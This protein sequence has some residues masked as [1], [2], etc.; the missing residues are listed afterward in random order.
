M[1]TE[2]AIAPAKADNRLDAILAANRKTGRGG[3]YSVCSANRLVIEAALRLAKKRA[4]IAVI[5]ATCNQ[6][7]P[8][9]GYTGMQPADFAALVRQKAN[10]VGFDATKLVLGGDHLGPQPW[11]KLGADQAM[12]KAETM[13]ADYARAGFTKLHLDCSMRCSDDPDPLPE[14][15]IAQ[16]AARLAR[17]AEMAMATEAKALRYVIGTEVPPPGGMGAGHEIVATDP[18]HVHNTW[19]THREAFADAGL[20]DA[21]ARVVGIVV[22]PGLDFGNEQVVDFAPDDAGVLSAALD[23]LE[24]AVYEAHSTDYQQPAAYAA[25]VA[26]HFA[27]L[28]VGPQATFAMR[29]ALY[30]LELIEREL[31]PDNPSRLRETLDSTMLASPD[32]W[33]THYRE[34]DLAYLRHFSL[35]DRIRYYWSRPEVEASLARLIGNLSQ[36]GLPFPLVSQYLAQHAPMISLGILAADPVEI[37]LANIENAL[38]PYAD[39][40]DTQTL[41]P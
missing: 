4:Q 2:H 18:A 40:C 21:F 22:Q 38:A 15:I 36:T 33:N 17:A 35:S 1:T 12:A 30:S 23:G 6:V 32:D 7:N 39:A 41:E 24:G 16:R 9:G 37:V 5:E 14:A 3:V 31:A 27:I 29:E 25:L 20:A 19:E 13:V 28:K 26:G 11:R 34:G 10:K 8:D